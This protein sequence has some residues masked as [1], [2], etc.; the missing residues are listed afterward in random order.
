MR[1]RIDQWASHLPRWL[2]QPL[3]RTTCAITG[4][5]VECCEAHPECIWCARA[6]R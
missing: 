1:S 2:A 5:H 6:T 4:G 3:L